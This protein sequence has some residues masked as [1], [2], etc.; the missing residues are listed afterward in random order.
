VFSSNVLGTM[1]TS[2]ASQVVATL[3]VVQTLIKILIATIYIAP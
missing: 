3:W 1:R 2:G